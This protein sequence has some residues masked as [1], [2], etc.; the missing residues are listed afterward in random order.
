[1]GTADKRII[2]GVSQAAN[3]EPSLRCCWNRS[4]CAIKSPC[5]AQPKLVA[6]A[7]A[8]GIDCFEFCSRV[9]GRKG[10]DSL[11]FVHS[12]T[13][14]R[15]R[16]DGWSALWRYRST[17]SLARRAPEISSEVRHLIG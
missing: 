2:L 8:F 12:E 17:G 7:F 13:V 5:R 1:M 3:R 15:W 9:G 6:R 11:I 16:R 14:L 4:R 10:F